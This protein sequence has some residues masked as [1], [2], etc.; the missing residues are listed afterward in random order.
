LIRHHEQTIRPV[1]I[2]NANRA[3]LTE[4][5]ITAYLLN[6]AHPAG[7]SKAAFFLRHGFSQTRWTELQSA[8]LRHVQENETSKQEESRHG[9]RFIVDGPILAPDGTQLNIRSAWYIDPSSD[10]PRFVTAHPL[11]KS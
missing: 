3:I 7:G 5:K 4:R 9:M 8:L 2:P 11:P 1:K 10:I 6:S